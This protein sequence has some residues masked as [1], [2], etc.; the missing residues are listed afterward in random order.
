MTEERK[1]LV[2]FKGVDLVFNKGKKNVNKAINDVS[3]HIY[4]GETFGLVGESGSGKTT[5]GRAIMKLYDINKGEIHFNGND[6]SKIKGAELKKFREKVQMIFQDP[7]AS[8]NG[9]MRVKDIIA[10]GIDVNGLAKNN[11]ERTEKVKELLK[12]V[13]LNQDH[14]TRYPHEF[15]GGQ[16]QRIGIARALAVNPKFIVAD[17]PI[18]ALDVSIQAQVVNLMRD[19]Q[20]KEGLTYLFIAHDLSMVK[21]I[22]DRIGVMHWG[23]ILEIGT[24]DQV[25]NNAL[26]PYT[27]SLL[28]AIPAPDPI[29]ERSRV[30]QAYDPT[31]EL[32]GQPRELR[33]ITPG[34]FV[35]STEE[36]AEE[37][38]KI[39]ML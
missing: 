20:E 38:R 24:S 18:S 28:S 19:I 17:E 16:R 14:M 5:I 8:L 31:T 36:E 25:Y 33:E 9:R 27:Q 37:Y 4:E 22:S 11:E 39:A 23:K 21:Y 32:D 15:S 2:E 35:L 12:L 26:H 7:Q 29:S 13:G 10:E 1:K 3:F 6:V 34:H 30:P